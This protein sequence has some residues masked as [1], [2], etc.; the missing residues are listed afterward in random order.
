MTPLITNFHWSTKPLVPLLRL[1]V[2]SPSD[3]SEWMWSPLLAS[4]AKAGAHR[5]DN[6]GEPVPPNKSITPEAVKRI[7]DHLVEVT[8]K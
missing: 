3:C 7:W 2:T 1:L 5:L 6:H 8:D 4:G